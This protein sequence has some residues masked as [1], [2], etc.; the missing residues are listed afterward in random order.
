MSA[1]VFFLHRC[2][3][4]FERTYTGLC[5]LH[6]NGE[7]DGHGGSF[8]SANGEVHIQFLHRIYFR[9]GKIKR[10]FC[11]FIDQFGRVQRYDPY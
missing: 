10:V 6:R 8:L 4:S 7:W 3:F 5:S 1:S 11:V 9:C 2:R